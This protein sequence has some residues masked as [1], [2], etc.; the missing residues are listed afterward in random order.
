MKNSMENKLK[1]RSFP[2]WR[3]MGNALLKKSN[4]NIGDLMSLAIF[5]LAMLCVLICFFECIGL[6]RVR[7]DVSQLARKYTLVA[8]TEGY[9]NEEEKIRLMDELKG[10]G[11]SD[12]DLTGTTFNRVGFGNIVTVK[13]SGKIKEKYSFTESRASTAKY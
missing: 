2:K 6:M 3:D 9:L 13:I 7:E 10:Y 11:I 12:I 1:Y 4:G 5:L 8:E